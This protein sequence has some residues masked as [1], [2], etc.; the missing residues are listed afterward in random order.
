MLTI[1]TEKFFEAIKNGESSKIA[2]MIEREP[3][4]VN[5][6]NGE[7]AT[8]ILYA[9]YTGRSEVAELIAKRKPQLDLF[10][11]ACLG[12]TARIET[13]IRQNPE[14]SN[15]YS[16]E[17][18]TALQLAAYLGKSTAVDLLLSRGAEVNA[19]AKNPT[20]YTALTGAVARGHRDIVS[21]LL[22]KGANPNPKYEGGFTP[23]MEAAASGDVEVTRLLLAHG[24]DRSI[25][26][27][28]KTAFDLAIEKGKSAT[29]QLLK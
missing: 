19:V 8:G 17:G 15:E 20:H 28:G 2:E 22:G 5:S 14:G 9:L 25:R 6:K 16:A 26:F 18:F 12:Q 21:T 1:E 10:E 13:L 4:I 3:T 24:A 11:A 29:A 23:L 27:N 7:G